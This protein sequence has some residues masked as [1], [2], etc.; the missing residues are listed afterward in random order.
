MYHMYL[1]SWAG[2]NLD[3]AWQNGTVQHKGFIPLEW[4]KEHHYPVQEESIK[5]KAKRHSEIPKIAKVTIWVI[6]Q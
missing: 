6:I 2:D 4:L 5:E 3:L 1:L